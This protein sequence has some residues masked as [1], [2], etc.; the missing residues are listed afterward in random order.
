M[1]FLS[2]D[3]KLIQ[4]FR[5]L[6]DYIG[7]NMMFLLCC[8][9]VLTIGSA[10]VAFYTALR[11]SQRNEPWC[12]LFWKTFVT[13]LKQPTILWCIC[14]P[15]LIL[16][17]LNARNSYSLGQNFMGVISYI[18]MGVVMCVAS[19]AP[20]FFSR[21]DCTVKEMAFNSLKMLIA[22]P[23]RILLGTAL[24][25]APVAF[26]LIPLL[27]WIIFKWL[28]IFAL[29]YFSVIGAFFNWMM[30]KPFGLITG[31]VPEPEE[32][33]LIREA[34]KNLEKFEQEVLQRKN[35]AQAASDQ[36]EAE[37]YGDETAEETE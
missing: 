35:E 32:S 3:S 21:F 29:L 34:K 27:N 7:L 9:P 10:H 4:T 25:W 28:F 1:K 19:L 23:V 24:T 2:Y 14:L 15:L 33:Y 18:C 11:A 16:F 12:A 37:E 13:S 26:Y 8:I 6:F 31:D 20:M 36:E 30:R 17:S 5:V 22:F